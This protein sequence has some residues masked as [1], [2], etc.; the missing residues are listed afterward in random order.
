MPTTQAAT[1]FGEEKGIE[2]VTSRAAWREEGRTR[3][4]RRLKYH[5]LQC[6]CGTEEEGEEEEEEEEEM[7]GTNKNPTKWLWSMGYYGEEDVTLAW[8]FNFLSGRDFICR[9]KQRIW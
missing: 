2:S 4:E 3:G 1:S 7:S 6:L 8:G 9:G 5:L